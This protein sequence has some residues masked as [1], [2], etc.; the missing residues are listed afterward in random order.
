M[1]SHLA[2]DMWNISYDCTIHHIGITP[3]GL[4][5]KPTQEI[6]CTQV[7]SSLYLHH[8][9]SPGRGLILPNGTLT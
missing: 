1:W 3:L 8:V 7:Y 5:M 2:L 4:G 9:V 6:S